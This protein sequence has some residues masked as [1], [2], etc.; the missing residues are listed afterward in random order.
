MVIVMKEDS[1]KKEI[2]GVLAAIRQRGLAP[3]IISPA[4]RVVVGI[5]EDMDEQ[6]VKDLTKSLAPMEC[7]EGIETF[8]TSWKLVPAAS[9]QREPPS[10]W[11]GLRSAV[12]AS[13]S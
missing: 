10:G 12:P 8:G 5:V 4:P 13:Q 11:A 7:V 1:R 9:E 3:R 6:S 2:G